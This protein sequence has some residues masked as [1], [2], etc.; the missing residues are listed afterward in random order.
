MTFPQNSAGPGEGALD[1]NGH[2]LMGRV[3]DDRQALQ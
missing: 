3:V 1:L 2:R